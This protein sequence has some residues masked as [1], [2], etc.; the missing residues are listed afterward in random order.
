[1]DFVDKAILDRNRWIEIINNT[2]TNKQTVY[3]NKNKI[4]KRAL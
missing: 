3:L 1:M 4:T 2:E